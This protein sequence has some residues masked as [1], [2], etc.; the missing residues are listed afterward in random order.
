MVKALASG[1]APLT[2][3]PSA[4]GNVSSTF[5]AAPLGSPPYTVLVAALAVGASAND[6][7][8]TPPR[9]AILAIHLCMFPSQSVPGA[10]RCR[11]AASYIEP[12]VACGCRHLMTRT[13]KTVAAV[14]QPAS[15]EGARRLP[16]R[17][18]CEKPL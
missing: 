3:R 6:T 8:H 9:P 14:P 15:R 18:A 16:V 11:R 2:A 1:F 12:N 4:R 13:R 7:A 17:L 10:I 5:F